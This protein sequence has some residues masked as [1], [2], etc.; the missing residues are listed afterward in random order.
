MIK[1]LILSTI[2]SSGFAISSF[3]CWF[4]ESNFN[5]TYIASVNGKHVHYT[6][7]NT[8]QQA[9]YH[10]GLSVDLPITVQ[11][12]V[13]PRIADQT[14]EVEGLKP[15]RTAILQYKIIKQNGTSIPFKTVKKIDNPNWPMN[16]ASPV[17]LFGVTG[18]I[19]IPSSKISAGDTIIIRVYFSDGTYYTGDLDGDLT[20][21]DVPDTQTYS[22][23]ECG[24]DGWRAPHVFRVIFSGKRRA[25]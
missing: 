21:A 18:K 10:N 4:T 5:A 11:I 9:T 2:F 13:S 15:I 12:K 23:P 25:E 6:P 14:G 3:A 7:A 16:F 19:S 20:I 17:N 24:Y 1:K 22:N 8:I